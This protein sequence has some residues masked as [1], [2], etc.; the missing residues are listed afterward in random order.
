MPNIADAFY[1]CDPEL[2][3]TKGYEGD[4]GWDLKCS[5]DTVIP[6]GEIAVIPTG[7]RMSLSEG[8]YGNIKGRSSMFAKRKL[9][10]AEGVVDAHYRGEISVGIYN[11]NKE[12]VLISRGDRVAQL[13]ITPF[14]GQCLCRVTE[15]DPTERGERGFGS[16]GQ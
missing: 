9:I 14:V 3:P 8:T 10:V 16:S 4:A 1:V 12:A 6:P 7:L 2:A 13:I 15:L 5:V 11:P